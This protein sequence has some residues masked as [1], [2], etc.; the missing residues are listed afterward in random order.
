M[1][2]T[3]ILIL[4]LFAIAG[5]LFLSI[6]N[7]LGKK[8]VIILNKDGLN[9]FPE[10]TQSLSSLAKQSEEEIAFL[11]NI[12]SGAIDPIGQINSVRLMNI[13]KIY[14]EPGEDSIKVVT[15]SG[16]THI[17]PTR[18]LHTCIKHSISRAILL[19]EAPA[20][21]LNDLLHTERAQEGYLVSAATSDD[22]SVSHFDA[23]GCTES[24]DPFGHATYRW[25]PKP[26]RPLPQIDP[27]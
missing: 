12:R 22:V 25:A 11:I 9:F 16:Y 21:V 18:V 15:K 27:S 24:P 1:N 17:I 6:N 19:L 13:A 23:D 20:K 8:F 5:C 7:P 10:G 2:P 14:A 3:E 26:A 4:A